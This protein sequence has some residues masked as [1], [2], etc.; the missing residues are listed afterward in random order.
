MRTAKARSAEQRSPTG[1]QLLDKALDMVALIE[2][3]NQRMTANA[4]ALASGY[5]K[6]TVNRILSALVRRDLLAVDRRD[7]TYELGMRFMQLAAAFRRS[8]RLVALVE[9][10]LIVLSTRTGESVS[11]GVP[12]PNSVRIVGRYQLG[13]ETMP[14]GPMGAKRPYHATSIGKA[15]LAGMNEKR[16]QKLLSRLELTDFTPN[17]MT[18]AAALLPE[19][20]LARARGYAFDDEE[21]V[22]GIRCV[23][24]PLFAI[25][26][27][28]VG[29]V[30]LSAPAH[31]M[32][33]ERINEIVAALSAIAEK[34]AARLQAPREGERDQDGIACLHAGG[35]YRPIA[36]AA[37]ADRIRVVDAA[38]PAIYNFSQR[39]DLLRMI[40][41]DRVPDAAALGPSGAI[42]LAQNGAIQFLQQG[43]KNSIALKP[44]VAALTFAPDGRAFAAA[45]GMLYNALTGKRLFALNGNA[46]ALAAT[47]DR[48]YVLKPGAIEQRELVSGKLL[49]RY[50]VQAAIG[51][52]CALAADSQHIWI[53]GPNSW[54]LERIDI[55][56]AATMRLTA[57]ERS[58][59]ALA[60]VDN[61][62]ILAGANLHAS[63]I[64]KVE[65]S[66]GS[67]YR[68][69]GSVVA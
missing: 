32:P 58:I 41:L 38:A 5:P 25:H 67:L 7:Q 12:E 17:T 61:S 16:M 52:H 60:T 51:S 8:H 23:G 36:I 28:L 69:R 34:V 57:P 2:T 13:L 6:P 45:G 62:V 54:R 33:T 21:I 66:S 46:T 50:G 31:R 59:T 26:G 39:G 37:D 42:L 53:S 43:K 20:K 14:G 18:D 49:K 9:E 68:L 30:S 1:T 44:A 22:K 56:T 10:E 27:D 11:L 19:L 4:V 48:L 64:D 29:A 40:R 63:L 3:S 47:I 24:V 35:L 15:M 65:H 55:A